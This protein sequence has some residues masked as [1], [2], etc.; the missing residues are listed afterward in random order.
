MGSKSGG[1]GGMQTV[2][3]KTELPQ[4]VQDAGQQNLAKAYEVSANLLGPYEGPRY[5]GITQ[6]AQGNIAEQRR[7]HQPGLCAGAEF[8]G[9]C[10]EL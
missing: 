8:C 2:T 7:Q 5:A 1:G 10:G 9:Q 3:Q 6:G 4:W